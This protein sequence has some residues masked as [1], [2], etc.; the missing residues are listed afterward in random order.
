MPFDQ[1]D[2]SF[3]GPGPESVDHVAARRP[4]VVV[5]GD[6]VL[7][8]WKW[9]RCHRLC[10]E[11]PVPVV[12]VA[13]TAK[14]PGA[15]ANTV[16]NLAAL[17]ARVRLVAAVGDDEAGA[18]LRDS[19]RHAG[20][21]TDT[22]LADPARHTELK[23]RVLADEQILLRYDEDR[24]TA[25]TDTTALLAA[26]DTALADADALLICDYG[27]T[28]DDTVRAALCARRDSLPCW[29]STH[30]HRPAGSHCAPIW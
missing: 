4:R 25:P 3:R 15:A 9:G 21:D 22:L 29:C 8:V 13:D 19:L 17:G 7:D 20:V 18:T 28:L 23:V 1:I 12:D 11:G 2:P 27:A 10:R 5:L 26:L 14:V 6:A 30:T 24:A 16:V